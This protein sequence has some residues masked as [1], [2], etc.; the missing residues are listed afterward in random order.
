[1]V[2]AFS[3]LLPP[4][5]FAKYAPTR[6]ARGG[7]GARDNS[8]L[9]PCYK[10]TQ[11]LTDPLPPPGDWPAKKKIVSSSFFPSPSTQQ[12]LS[13]SGCFFPLPFA[14][15]LLYYL[16]LLRSTYLHTSPFPSSSSPDCVSLDLAGSRRRRRIL[17]KESRGNLRQI[18]RIQHQ[19]GQMISTALPPPPPPSLFIF[20][21]CH[22]AAK[23]RPRPNLISGVEKG[24]LCG[25][26]GWGL[27]L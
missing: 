8:T 1:M 21:S 18:V 13:L 12:L 27:R 16:V 2:V 19:K 24:I 7:G 11:A 6:P 25:W 10:H 26:V 20:Q 9:V 14:F 23:R 3:Y 4:H 22:L 17:R 15:L 5:H